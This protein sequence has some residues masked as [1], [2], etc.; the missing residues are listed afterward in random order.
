VTQTVMCWRV[1]ASNVLLRTHTCTP[2]WTKA[3]AVTS[4]EYM[5]ASLSTD[6]AASTSIIPS[7]VCTCI[8][9]VPADVA[10]PQVVVT[11]C[12]DILLD[13]SGLG[14]LI[15]FEYAR[16]GSHRACTLEGPRLVQL[17][18]FFAER[19]PARVCAKIGQHG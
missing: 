5:L 16:Y 4:V 18:L 14:R 13:R 15:P 7:H 19:L 1:N 2:N 8:P 6:L 12:Y 9:A 10:G 17:V 11:C 3:R